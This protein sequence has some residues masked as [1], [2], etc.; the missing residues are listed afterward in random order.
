LPEEALEILS[1]EVSAAYPDYQIH[2][3]PDLDI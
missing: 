1:K 2:I 3:A